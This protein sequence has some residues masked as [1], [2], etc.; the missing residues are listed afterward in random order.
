MHYSTS[1]YNSQEWESEARQGVTG[2]RSGFAAEGDGELVARCFGDALVF[3]AQ[4][5]TDTGDLAPG[6]QRMAGLELVGE[7]A[8]GLGDDLDASARPAVACG[9]RIRLSAAVL[10]GGTVREAGAIPATDRVEFNQTVV[11]ESGIEVATDDRPGLLLTSAV[12][13]KTPCL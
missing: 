5:V 11:H 7:M 2:A 1:A 12:G 8:A 13:G 6:D 3:V 9:V 4:H 10:R